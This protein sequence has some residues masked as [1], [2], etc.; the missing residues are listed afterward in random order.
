MSRAELVAALAGREEGVEERAVEGRTRVE[1]TREGP[2]GL[3]TLRGATRENTLALETLERLAAAA[4]EL[5]GEAQVRLVAITGAGRIF[6]AGA[7][8]AAI[9]ELSGEEIG[10]R[11]TA[12]CARITALPV[13]T[14]ALLN[15]HAVGGAI[16]L[17]LACDWRAAAESAKLRFIHNELGYS[18]PW[19]A[20]A[21]IAELLP[22]GRALSLF[23]LCR[24]VSAAEAER[25]GLVDEVVQGG[26]ERLL[27]LAR[28]LAARGAHARPE[29]VAET[30][31]LLRER[32][33]LREHERV[34]AGFWDDA[35]LKARTSEEDAGGAD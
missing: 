10:H 26:T 28:G 33:P 30:R 7:D 23:A 16:D 9:G 6:S 22:A 21:R 5:A 29:A 35:K 13:P 34:F 14:L 19:G 2:L 20:A 3:V 25:L 24:T 27:E 15:G 32:P 17:A 4:E 18:P 1:V 12:A 11:G 8:L 31:R